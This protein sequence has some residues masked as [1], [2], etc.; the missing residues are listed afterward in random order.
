MVLHSMKGI[1]RTMAGVLYGSG[2]RLM[3]CIRLRVHD[4]DFDM[5]QIIVRSGKGM[6][7]RVTIMPERLK[8]SLQ[9]QL[10][11]MESL[12]QK[13][14]SQG[15]GYVYLPFALEKKLK[16]RSKKQICVKI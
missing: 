4:I 7:D 1:Y 10:K 14:I 16:P 6:K 9:A 5:L 2:L 13:D 15:Y 8:S 3:E 12:H 11:F